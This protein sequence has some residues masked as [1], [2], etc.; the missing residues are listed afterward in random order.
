MTR[1]SSRE[2][3]AFNAFYIKTIKVYPVYFSKHNLINEKQI[4]L[5][6]IMLQQKNYLCY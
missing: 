3:I 1:E 4:I 6:S 2:T 5:I